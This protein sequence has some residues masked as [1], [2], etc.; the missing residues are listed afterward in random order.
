MRRSIALSFIFLA[1][2]TT[3]AA[4]ASPS[5]RAGVISVTQAQFAAVFDVKNPVNN[6]LQN[7]FMLP[8]DNSNGVFRSQVFKSLDKAN[9]I[10]AYLYQVMAPKKT[11]IGEFSLLPFDGHVMAKFGGMTTNSI[12]VNA[13][14]GPGNNAIGGFKVLGDT[15]PTD[16][17]FQP[18]PPATAALFKFNKS[19]PAGKTSYIV[20]VFSTLAP[21]IAT[22]L[23]ID[24]EKADPK[25]AYA[26]PKAPEP[27]SLLTAGSALLL[28]AGAS[29][30]RR[31]GFAS[32]S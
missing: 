20:G 13:G 5:S 14:V 31:S 30:R 19:I 9:V 15:A 10:Y 28:A 18:G 27:P 25:F 26:T 16:V 6:F 17:V 32:T 29:R 22:S 8:D 23:K 24:D 2:A 11:K 7:N 21:E 1:V 4:V 3:I 12:Y